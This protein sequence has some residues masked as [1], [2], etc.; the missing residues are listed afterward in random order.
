M[1]RFTSKL[2]AMRRAKGSWLCL[3]CQAIVAGKVKACAN[4]K[5]DVQYFPSQKELKRACMLLL[6]EQK[7][8]I[9]GLKFHPR[10]PLTV[11]GQH[12]TT[13]VADAAYVEDSF[14]VVEDTKPRGGNVDP[15]AALKIELFNA[16]YH[17]LRVRIV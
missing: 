2:D 6:L 15:V 11:N 1:T 10:Y 9:T 7:R 16:C 12:V 17:P 3:G 13:Y 5:G 14:P 4:C 8:Q